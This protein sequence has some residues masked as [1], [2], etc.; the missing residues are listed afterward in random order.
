MILF[1]QYYSYLHLLDQIIQE[2]DKSGKGVMKC[3]RIL[4]MRVLGYADGAALAEETVES[5]TERLITTIA[6]D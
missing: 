2:Y 5:M 3:G 1:H 4:K 6:D